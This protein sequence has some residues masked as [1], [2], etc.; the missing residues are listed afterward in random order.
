RKTIGMKSGDVF[1][2][3]WASVA[4]AKKETRKVHSGSDFA[5]A[6]GALIAELRGDGF[7]IGVL[8]DEAHHGF[9]RAN[10][11]VS[12]YRE[13]LRPEFTLMIT[14][15]P[16]DQDVEKF[17]KAAGIGHLHRIR[18]SR[19]EAVDAGLI[20]EGIKSIAYLAA[21][22]Q[23]ELVDF[24]ATALSDGWSMHGAVKQALHA[25]GI[26]LVPLMLVQVGNSNAAVEEARARLASMGVPESKIAWYTAA[27][28]NNDL[29]A[30]AIDE[31]KEVLIFKVA[32]ALG[33]DAPR[34]FTLVSMRGASDTDFGIQVVGRILRVQG[35]TLGNKLPE[36]LRYG[37]VFLAD[38]ANQSGLVHA[39][40][41]INAIQSELS[42]IC[43][44]TM[45]VKIAG[46]NEIQVTHNGQ[47]QLFSVPYAPPAW[48]VP[49]TNVGDAVRGHFA[50]PPAWQPEGILTNLVLLP[51]VAPLLPHTART[52]PLLSGVRRYPLRKGVPS[53]YRSERLPLSTAD[54]LTCIAA[55]IAINDKVFNAGFRQSVKVTRHT[56]DLFEGT[57]ETES[58]QA[59]LSDAEIARRAQSVMFDA[60]YLDSRDLHDALLSRLKSEFGHRGIDINDGGLPGPR[61]SDSIVSF[62]ILGK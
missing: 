3:T 53:I 60:E 38:A 1:V 34:A 19:K 51:E 20:K 6:L 14:A 61:H 24:A 26:G 29:L 37:Y 18:V 52:S 46:R 36:L 17:K 33:F 2:T 59:R 50:A 7:R 42:H 32:V 13:M 5:L 43:P 49:G 28:P 11:A 54:L 41:K 12:L 58:M 39:G 56:V 23:K 30:A 62:V 48:P 21:D 57:E 27:D 4:A 47:P 44:F 9:A 10:E 22:G 35:L 31:T 45:V 25:A 15:T 8:V 16:D 40:E 55:N